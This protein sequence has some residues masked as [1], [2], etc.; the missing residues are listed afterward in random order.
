MTPE[1][2]EVMAAL[3]GKRFPLED[4][5]RCQEDIEKAL[6]DF[7]VGRLISFKREVKL[8]PG[9]VVDFMVGLG[10]KG[11]AVEVKLKGQPE[12]IRR[13]LRRYAGLDQVEGLILVTA[14][15][16]GVV[17]L[18]NGKPVAEFDLSRAWL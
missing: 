4:E 9:D 11:T 16:V 13:Q 1:M 12:A 7:Y 10:W 8:G 17:G 18:M 2:R 3:R 15:P 5:K 14:K 6:R